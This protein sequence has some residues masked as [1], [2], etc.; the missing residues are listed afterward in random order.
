[1]VYNLTYYISLHLLRQDIGDDIGNPILLFR[2][3]C[4]RP[5]SDHF[6]VSRR[7]HSFVFD[8]FIFQIIHPGPAK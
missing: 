6:D 1:M 4:C 3:Y 7:G 5:R 2:V 8:F